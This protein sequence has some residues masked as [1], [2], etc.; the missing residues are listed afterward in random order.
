M[1]LCCDAASPAG[2]GQPILPAM[3]PR[4]ENKEIA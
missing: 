2:F 4:A 1:Q 3:G